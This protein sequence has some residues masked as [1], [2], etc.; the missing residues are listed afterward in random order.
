MLLYALIDFFRDYFAENTFIRILDVL[1]I[2]LIAVELFQFFRGTTAWRIFWGLI[3][4]YVLWKIVI[5]FKMP[6]LSEILGQF[7]SLGIIL[8]IILFQPEI[9]KFLLAL[10][11]PKIIAQKRRRFFIWRLPWI[12]DNKIHCE[13]LFQAI[14][15]F[16]H[17]KIGALI[18]LLRKD[19]IEDIVSTGVIIDAEVSVSLLESIFQKHSPLHDGAV[20]L[21][22]NRILAARCILPLSSSANLPSSVGLRHRAA[23]GLSEYSDALVIVVSEQNGSISLALQGTMHY[24]LTFQEL[25]MFLNKEILQC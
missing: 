5:F 8:L 17:Q 4:I 18:V 24:N 12:D 23:L 9:R 10:G 15:R 3:I 25:E 20:I 1:I 6:L 13:V 21:K 19:T 22:D 2:V 16:S 14:R 7:I 11:N